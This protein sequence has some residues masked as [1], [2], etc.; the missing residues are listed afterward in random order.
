MALNG[1]LAPIVLF[2]FNRPWHLKQTVESL[3]SSLLASKSELF[4]YSDGPKTDADQMLVREVRDYVKE[5][6]GFKNITLITSAK[7][8][9]L[10]ASVI[11]GVSEIVNRY[12][13][14]IVLEDDMLSTPDFLNFMNDTLNAYEF[15]QDIFSVS[16][17]TP[18]LTIPPDYQADLYLAPRA[19]SWGWGTWAD[20]WE[21]ADWNVKNFDDIKKKAAAQ[22]ELKNGG[23]DLWPMLV[24]QQRGVI[25]SWA[26]RWTFSQFNHQAYGLYPVR[27]KIKN[28]GTDGSGTN[29]T[30]TSAQYG[31][32]M[33]QGEV[34][35]DPELKPDA[36]MIAS[37]R[38]Y[39]NLPFAIK[40]KN[41]V[42]YRI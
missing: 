36:E 37:F 38:K 39:Y 8:K 30:F 18:P 2:C 4:I 20:K 10:A 9:G 15:R 22:R 16:G 14:V 29:F 42:K 5:I 41:W 35:M 23:N 34:L 3:Q 11:D 12:K 25:D 27:S 1:N 32:E 19:S 28:I 13:K 26:I 6:K 24:K 40:I 21:K 33:S 17:Y 7:N 31:K